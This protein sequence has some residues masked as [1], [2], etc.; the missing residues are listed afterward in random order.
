MAIFNSY[1]DI[2]RGYHLE[3]TINL[4]LQRWEVVVQLLLLR[5]H[6]CQQLSFSTR[7]S[8]GAQETQPG[9]DQGRWKMV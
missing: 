8:K 1:F 9:P 2:T 6:L 5:G 7:A 3:P 4:Q